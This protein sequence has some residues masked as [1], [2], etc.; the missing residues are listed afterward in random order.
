MKKI[1]LTCPVCNQPLDLGADEYECVQVSE[2]SCRVVDV[3]SLRRDT[4]GI[5]CFV[6]QHHFED[7]VKMVRSGAYP[8]HAHSL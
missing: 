7:F 3:K 2:G 4:G 5:V 6:H 1:R 8:R